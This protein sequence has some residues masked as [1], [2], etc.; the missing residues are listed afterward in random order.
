MFILDDSGSM[1]YDYLPDEANFA[2][3]KYGKLTS[4]C[5]GVAYN[6][7]I[8]YSLP[9]DATGNTL[10]PGSMAFLVLD[11]NTLTTNQRSLSSPT[12]V[13]VPATVGTD[14]TLT[15]SGTIHAQLVHGRRYGD[16][17]QHRQHHDLGRRHRQEL[18]QQHPQQLVVTVSS[19]TGS[20]TLGS[21]LRVGD[22][23]P[24]AHVLQ[25]HRHRDADVLHLHELGGD[26]LHQFLQAVQ[27]HDRLLARFRRLHAPS[28]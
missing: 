23:E 18:E 16:D 3:T 26:H 22:G 9:V 20:A 24:W 17:L 6:P 5:N 4:Q 8:T 11:P 27:Q 28:R 21:S 7:N 2:T 14:L 1:K 25:V 10:S 19:S 13:V 12:S 15:V